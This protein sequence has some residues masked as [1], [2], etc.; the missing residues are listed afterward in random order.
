[1]HDV[2][3]AGG[4]PGGLYAGACLARRGLDVVLCE[5]H[6]AVGAP[7]HC[8]GV[9]ARDAFDEFDLDRRAVLNE[10][11]SVRFHAPSGE[12]V[13]YT[14]PTVEA[15]VIDRLLFDRDLAETAIGAGV[16]LVRGRK[17]TDIAVDAS[18]VAV[19]TRDGTPLRGRAC[20]LACG[21][22]YGIQRRFGLGVPE[23]FLQSAQAEVPCEKLD[24][25][26]VHFGANVA[27][28]GF[29]WA[30]P[31]CRPEGRYVRVGVMCSRGAAYYFERLMRCISDRWCVEASSPLRPRLK[32]LPLSPISKTF[33]DRLLVLGDAAGLVKPTTGGGIHYSLV[34]A[35]I[36][37]DVLADALA[38]NDCSD[39]VLGAYQT[40]WR[41]RL[42]AEL[43]AQM[44][45][46]RVAER[47][48][49]TEINGLF[50][51]A[52]VD[53]VMPIVRRTAH[54]NRHRDLILAL[55]KHPPVRRV[56][57]RAL[58]G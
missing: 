55:L 18:G 37:A 45:L 48:T 54:F 16:Q 19:M 6:D 42:W 30:V 1:M 49:D 56:L 2:I 46:R 47:M 41:E 29:G 40:R 23:M 34:S 8:T 27:P 50:E 43:D 11:T 53:G 28:G 57:F 38:R 10:L 9:F 44:A 39:C 17:V 35:S 13:S 26:E 12:T 15:V 51:L 21:A 36:A 14:T 24:D 3:I 32:I 58:A 7:V 52:R 4:G 22:R 25:V 20:I 5:E 33:A 31:V